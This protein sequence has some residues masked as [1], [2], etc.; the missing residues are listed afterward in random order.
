MSFTVKDDPNLIFVPV[1]S[2]GSGFTF[3][4]QYRTNI[5]AS[6]QYL[7]YNCTR[8][9]IPRPLSFR[10]SASWKD[11]LRRYELSLSRFAGLVRLLYVLFTRPFSPQ[12]TFT[13]NIYYALSQFPWSNRTVVALIS[14][15]RFMKGSSRK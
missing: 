15:N 5:L 12:A 8:L 4:L 10:V 9:S 1:S 14:C 11:D 2:S 3:R 13:S 7:N 6:A